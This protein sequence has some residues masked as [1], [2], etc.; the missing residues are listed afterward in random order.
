MKITILS[1]NNGTERLAGEWGLSIW[2]EYGGLRVLLDAG[3]SGLFLRNA[4][5]LGKDPRSLDLA[6]LSHAHYDHAD[7]FV[8]LLRENPALRVYVR[9]CMG[10]DCYAVK[11]T[12]MEYIG[13]APALLEEFEDRLERV[14]GDRQIAEG[15]WLIGH[16]KPDRSRIGLREGMF[17]RSGGE[18]IPD[19]FSHEQSL[20]F[21][22]EKGLCVFNSCSHAGAAEILGEVRQAF[23]GQRVYAYIGGFHLY[24]K[25]PEE[26]RDFAR[27]LKADGAEKLCTGH[28]TG[29]EAFAILKQEL[30]DRITQFHVGLEMEL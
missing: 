13:A 22:T 11:D 20:V 10:A 28:C 7:G 6:V 16:R 29:E 1:D 17:V 30:G 24:R 14:D 25:T 2:I 5:L 9:R 21:R 3:A 15:V 26:V 18:M 12:G 23:P 19:D 27:R 4:R 8:P